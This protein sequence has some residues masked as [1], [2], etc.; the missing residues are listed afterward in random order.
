MKK[1]GEHKLERFP[2]LFD[3]K[4][5]RRAHTLREFDDVVT[6]PLHGFRDTDD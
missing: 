6:A 1:K 2:G 5:M 3:G 4:A